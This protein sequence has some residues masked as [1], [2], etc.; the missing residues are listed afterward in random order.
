MEDC[1]H[2]INIVRISMVLAKNDLLL[3][4]LALVLARSEGEGG[5]II[6]ISM[7]RSVKRIRR[8]VG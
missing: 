1:E 4:I 2:N 7:L 8:V 5:V 3:L 6:S